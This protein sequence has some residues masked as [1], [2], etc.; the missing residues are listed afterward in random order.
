LTANLGFATIKNTILVKNMENNL[1]SPERGWIDKFRDAFRG[2]AVGIR[3]QSSFY[4]HFGF[5]LAVI[6]AAATLRV[7]RWEWCVLILC[8]TVVFTAEMFNTALESMARAISREVHP[9]LGNALDIGSAAVLTASIGAS[10]IG[11]IIFLNR[12]ALA[13]GWWQ[14]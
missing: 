8:I 4:A 11:A 9:D 12:L 13:L 1:H 3:G 6:A 14:G 2:V 10:I 5:A 7:A